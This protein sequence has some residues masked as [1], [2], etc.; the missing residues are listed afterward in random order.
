MTVTRIVR[1]RTTSAA[2][3]A[4][5][6]LIRAVF[7][8]LATSDPGGMRY[9]A[10]RLED[11]VSFVHIASFDGDNNPLQHS[12]AFARFQSGIGERCIEGPAAAEAVAL[13][14]YPPAAGHDGR[15]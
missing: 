10:Y 7:D 6:D 13:G 14:S 8:E 11:G 2:A 1:Y 5:A 9:T 4:N 3:D 15:A 12:A